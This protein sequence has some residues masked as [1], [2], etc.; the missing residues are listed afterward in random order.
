MYN[1]VIFVIQLTFFFR[2]V[3]VKQQSC[4]LKIMFRKFILRLSYFFFVN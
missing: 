3:V 1:S 4:D 2:I